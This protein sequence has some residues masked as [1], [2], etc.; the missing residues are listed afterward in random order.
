MPRKPVKD[1][2]TMLQEQQR[3][4][5][6]VSICLRGD[7]TAEIY[8]LDRQLAEIGQ[9]T[10]RKL[11]DDPAARAAAKRLEALRAEAKE[12]TVDVRLRA[13][14][15]KA[16]ADLVAKHPPKDKSLDFDWAIFNEVIPLS[17]IEPE[18]DAE[19]RDK[20]LEGLT[21]GQWDELAGAAFALNAGPGDVPFSVRASQALQISDETSEQPATEG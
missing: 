16:W 12:Y 13:L 17:I 19:T 5:S 1:L 9:A 21:Q 3:P 11:S 8:L 6:V 10:T 7:L 4:E 15:H 20:L 2:R 18:M 14:T